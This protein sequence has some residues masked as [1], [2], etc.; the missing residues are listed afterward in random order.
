HFDNG[1][2]QGGPD[3][4]AIKCESIWQRPY[5]NAVEWSAVAGA[6]TS[7]LPLSL[8]RDPYVHSIKYEP[9]GSIED[10]FLLIS[11]RKSRPVFDDCAVTYSALRSLRSRIALRPLR[12]GRTRDA[13]SS[14]RPG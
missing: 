12:T 2:K 9:A 5:G 10:V 7:K 1:T 6:E 3:V 14:R 13:V 8:F 11:L 4:C